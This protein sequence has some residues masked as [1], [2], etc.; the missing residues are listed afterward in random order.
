MVGPFT[1]STKGLDGIVLTLTKRKGSSIAGV[2]VD[3]RG[4]P[5]EGAHVNL[6]RGRADY[7]IDS[8]R[9][10]SQSDGS[11]KIEELV[12]G[13][14]GVLLTAPGVTTFSNL[15]EVARLDVGEGQAVTGLRLVLGADKGGLVIAGRVIDASGKP[16]ESVDILASGPTDGRTRTDENGRFMLTGLEEGKYYLHATYAASRPDYSPAQLNNVE[17]GAT[18]VVIELQRKARIEGRVIRADTGEPVPAFEVF[19]LLGGATHVEP[20]IFMNRRAVRNAEGRFTRTVRP[21]RGDCDG[22]SAGLHARLSD[23]RTYRTRNGEHRA[24]LGAG[25]RHLRGESLTSPARLCRR[26]GST[27]AKSRTP[28]PRSEAWR[29]ATRKAASQ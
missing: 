21:R 29:A 7:L 20:R 19:L 8:G 27:L 9:A 12:S 2:V 23:T 3:P 26:Q 28:R 17:A 5:V 13:A 1:L 18:D 22:Q 16:V 11:F 10:E 4:R 14:Y 24:A 15:D 6:D 25:G